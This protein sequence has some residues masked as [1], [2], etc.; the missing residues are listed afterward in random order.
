MLVQLLIIINCIL[1]LVKGESIDK[2]NKRNKQLLFLIIVGN[3]YEKSYADEM[4]GRI[5]GPN[6]STGPDP[7]VIFL[8]VFGLLVGG[9]F[10]LCIIFSI[11]F[12]IFDRG[13][14]TIVRSHFYRK[15]SIS[16]STNISN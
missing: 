8:M 5:R 1:I 12:G 10:T 13:F 14:L 11:F 6:P 16:T 3:A 4:Y 15:I 2:K 9:F 7:A